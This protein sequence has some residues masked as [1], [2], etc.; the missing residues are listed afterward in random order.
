MCIKFNLQIILNQLQ[1]VLGTRT[2]NV[3][4]NDESFHIV[5]DTIEQ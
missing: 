2:L 5:A 4:F 1:Q 3:C